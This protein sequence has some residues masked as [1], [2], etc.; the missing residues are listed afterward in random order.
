[1]SFPEGIERNVQDFVAWEE[2]RD[3]VHTCKDKIRKAK[4]Q[5]ELNIAR[6]LKNNKKGFYKYIGRKKQTKD[7]VPPLISKDRELAFSN[8]EKAE[9][10]KEFSALVFMG[11]QAPHVCQDLEPLGGGE[12]R[13]F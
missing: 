13:G 2:Y 8:I 1:M 6:D 10:L 12:R 4:V 3:V 7:N 5:M 11:G 9:V